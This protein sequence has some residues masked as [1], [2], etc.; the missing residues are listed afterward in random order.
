M[1]KSNISGIESGQ[2]SIKPEPVHIGNAIQ[3]MVDVV[4]PAAVKRRQTLFQVDSPA[5]QLFVLTDKRRLKQ[6]LLNLA[7]NAIKYNSIG[8]TVTIP[9]FSD[10]LVIKQSWQLYD[11]ARSKIEDGLEKLFEEL[12]INH[13]LM[14][15]E[16]KEIKDELIKDQK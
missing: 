16:L 15:E 13:G 9:Y 7:D 6:V 14:V 11:M 8:G 12:E 5:N 10:P 3:E 2:V 1:K 4:G